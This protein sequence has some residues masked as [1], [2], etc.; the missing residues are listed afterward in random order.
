MAD[1]VRTD[2]S[3]T[4]T[5]QDGSVD[6]D[7]IAI[8]DHVLFTLDYANKKAGVN[9]VEPEATLDVTGDIKSSSVIEGSKISGTSNQN[10]FGSTT[11]TGVM[12]VDGVTKFTPFAY[13]PQDPEEGYEYYN[14]NTKKKYYYNGLNWIPLT[15]DSNNLQVELSLDPD[16]TTLSFERPVSGVVN[17]YSGSFDIQGPSQMP[18]F[19]PANDVDENGMIDTTRIF[20]SNINTFNL[21]EV[22]DSITTSGNYLSINNNDNYYIISKQA[23]YYGMSNV[24]AIQISST[25]SGSAHGFKW[26]PQYTSVNVSVSRSSSG[27][28]FLPKGL[29]EWVSED[30]LIEYSLDKMV[31]NDAGG[32]HIPEADTPDGQRWNLSGWKI[33]DVNNNTETTLAA[34]ET[35]DDDA[36]TLAQVLNDSG[37]GNAGIL[38]LNIQNIL[39]SEKNWFQIHAMFEPGQADVT[40][41][42]VVTSRNRPS[43]ATD[44]NSF[45]KR[46][47][48]HVVNENGS[49][50]ISVGSQ[51]RTFFSHWEVN[52][53]TFN[54]SGSSFNLFLQN[55]SSNKNIIGVFNSSSSQSNTGG[56]HAGSGSAPPMAP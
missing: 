27:T 46:I 28:I 50:Q 49:F 6:I 14:A 7:N 39:Q 30:G 22:G 51:W 36:A 1:K 40:Y 11:V 20:T 34:G 9:N 37:A 19:N 3:S 21:L 2:I 41:N 5:N 8:K 25:E 23:Y 26:S 10:T 24:H 17:V 38:E 52:G 45:S 18:G 44:S 13:H 31:T 48:T 12:T 29:S 33:K 15:G 42:V 35:L 56:W 54:G 47:E 55:I 4:G 43:G 32:A 16:E 53:Q